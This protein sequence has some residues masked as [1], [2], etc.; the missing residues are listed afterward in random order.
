MTEEDDFLNSIKD[1]WV[2]REYGFSNLSYT[3]IEDGDNM[4]TYVII[5][6][7]FTGEKKAFHKGVRDKE[8][9]REYFSECGYKRIK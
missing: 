3:I 2:G 5:V 4:L 7:L 9:L 6:E 1:C 8:G